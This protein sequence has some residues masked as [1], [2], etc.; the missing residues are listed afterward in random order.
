MEIYNLVKNNDHT[1][2]ENYLQDHKD[3]INHAFWT[4]CYLNK[5][6]CATILLKY[7]VD[8]NFVNVTNKQTPLMVACMY[9][10][11]LIVELLLEHGAEPDCTGDMDVTPL[12]CASSYGNHKCIK[13]LYQYGDINFQTKCGDTALHF[14]IRNAHVECVKLLLENGADP[15]IKNIYGESPKITLEGRSLN[16]VH[17]NKVK[18][19]KQL[20]NTVDDLQPFVKF[21][22]KIE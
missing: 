17:K 3:D 9:G 6:D 2:L 4:S 1:L 21:A 15:N 10:H 16:F 22:G 19:M 7:S 20:I 18:Q 12:I 13:L 11:H 8:I 5:V 14:A